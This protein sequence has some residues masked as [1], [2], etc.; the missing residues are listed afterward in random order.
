MQPRLTLS[1]IALAVSSCALADTPTYELDDVVVTATRT[2]ITTEQATSDI[3]II[4]QEQIRNA[5]QSTL[6]ELLQA[7]PGVELAQSGGA[8]S[9][10]SLFIRGANSGH[11]LVLID[12]MRIGSATSGLTPLESIALDQIDHIEILRGAASSLYGSDAIG[13]VIQIFTKQGAGTPRLNA[14]I[15]LGSYGTN[16]LRAGYSGQSGDTR[17]SMGAGY[18]KTNGGFSATRPSNVYSYN[19][20]NDGDEKY[21]A[22]FNL[23]Q[24]INTGNNVGLI[25]LYNRD[26]VEY[27]ASN[28]TNDYAINEVNSLAAYWKSQFTSAWRSRL[29]IGQGQNNTHSFGAYPGVNNTKQTQYQWQNDFTLP[30]GTISASVERNEQRVDATTAYNYTGRNVN[31]AQLAYMATIGAHS[32]L[33]AVRHDDYSDLGGHDTGNL[34]YGYALNSAWRLTANAGTAFHAPSFD[35]LFYPGYSNPN[36]KPEQSEQFD[37]GAH[38]RHGVDRF[39]VT[40]FENRITDLIVSGPPDYLPYNTSKARIRGLELSADTIL[41][42]LQLHASYDLQDPRDET[43]GNMLARRARQHGTVDISKTIGAWN[44]GAQTIASGMRYDDPANSTRLG[45]YTLVNLRA[46][47]QVAAEWRLFAKLNNVFNKDYETVSGYN[48]PG[49]N[50]FVGLEWQQK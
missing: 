44:L 30:I 11:T 22:H 9:L 12:G 41:A 31:S 27:D 29:Q 10:S 23:D 7:Q 4:S 35:L 21:S 42:G 13:G 39:G 26:R 47:Y 2:P 46:A 20:D 48:T 50:L 36:L 14:A 6:T 15:G 8:G 32:L 37:L 1:V 33:A 25:S 49:A 40:A 5:G 45:G 19:P 18:D 38:Y 28:T 3:S 24:R 34:G 17:F 43:T 16:Q